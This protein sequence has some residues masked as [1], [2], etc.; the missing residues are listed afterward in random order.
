MTDYCTR[1]FDG[2]DASVFPYYGLA[3]HTHYKQNGVI[4]S[5]VVLPKSEWPENFEEDEDAPG[6]GIYTHC[7]EC[8]AGKTEEIS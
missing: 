3:P 8:G 7:P 2:N 5:T 1:C 6:A 4:G